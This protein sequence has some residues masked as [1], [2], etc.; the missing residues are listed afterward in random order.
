[1]SGMIDWQE[2]HR[3]YEDPASDLSRRR[4]VVQRLLAEAIGEHPGREA[5]VVSMCAGDGNDVVGV[6]STGGTSRVR[7][8]LVEADAG[9]VEAGR[10]RVGRA[11]LDGVVEWR[12]G[13]AADPRMYADHVPAQVVLV[14]GVFGNIA[15]ADVLATI[16]A[17]PQMVAPGGTV[18]WTRGRKEGD[19]TVAIRQAFEEVGF[20]QLAFVAPPDATFS[21]GAARYEGEPRRFEVDRHL[22]TFVR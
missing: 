16:R 21:V 10:D 5:T 2:W 8:L 7:A 22:F 18:I 9:L 13:D 11:G 12:V 3:E 1:M 4:R 17:L 14:C 20:R 15:W 19:V 6:L